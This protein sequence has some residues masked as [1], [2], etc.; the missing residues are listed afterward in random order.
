MPNERR[1]R[2]LVN[3][4]CGKCGAVITARAKDVEWFQVDATK[5]DDSKEQ[6]VTCPFHEGMSYWMYATEEPL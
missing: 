1:Q 2:K 5:E 6:H 3:L 4:S